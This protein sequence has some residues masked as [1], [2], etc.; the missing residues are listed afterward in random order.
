MTCVAVVQKSLK[1]PFR[2]PFVT[3]DDTSSVSHLT[4][5]NA[6]KIPVSNRDVVLQKWDESWQPWLSGGGIERTKYVLDENE[7][8]YLNG[9]YEAEE[10]FAIKDFLKEY[11]IV[12]RLLLDAYPRLRPLFGPQASI[13]LELFEEP[14]AA[15][16]RELFAVVK[17]SMPVEQAL[18]ALGAFDSSWWFNAAKEAKGRLNFTTEYL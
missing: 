15:R 12:A 7:Y 5:P 8:Q 9:V 1:E 13:A 18:L 6:H 2:P 10:P 11:P 14:D 3:S 16:S 17:T 4:A